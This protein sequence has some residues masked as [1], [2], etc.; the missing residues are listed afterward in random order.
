M[1]KLSTSEII[2][3]ASIVVSIVVVV[4]EEKTNKVTKW[5]IFGLLFAALIIY[6]TLVLVRHLRIRRGMSST[7]LM[8]KT[9]KYTM[10]IVRLAQASEKQLKHFAF[11]KVCGEWKDT[12]SSF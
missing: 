11:S 2:S 6:T 4:L 10:K 3:I 5:I 9:R 8:S 12:T 1:K 7:I